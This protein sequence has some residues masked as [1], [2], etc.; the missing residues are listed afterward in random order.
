[1]NDLCENYFKL[2]EIIVY[3]YYL[4]FDRFDVRKDCMLKRIKSKNFKNFI[5]AVITIEYRVI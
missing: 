3:P 5:N 2:V 4:N 1:M